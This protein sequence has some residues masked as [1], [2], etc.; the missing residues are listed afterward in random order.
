MLD[1]AIIPSK[2]PVYYVKEVSSTNDE[3]IKLSKDKNMSN[4]WVIAESQVKGR[5]RMGHSWESPKG[6]LFATLMFNAF[7]N[8]SN[9]SQLSLVASLSVSEA[10]KNFININENEVYLKWPN[11]ILVNRKK[12]SGV[13]IESKKDKNSLKIIIGIG[14]NTV[15]K[16][17]NIDSDPISL[18]ECSDKK[19]SNSKFF[20]TLLTYMDR[21]IVKLKNN[22]FKYI[23]N[24]WL[25]NA[26][27]FNKTI[28]VKQFG[29]ETITGIFCGLGNSGELVI[30]EDNKKTTIVNGTIL[31]F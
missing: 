26:I 1:S 19:I 23:R 9:I 4:F 15:K 11:D 12:I 31:E 14:V 6:N 16:P 17:N 18:Y 24:K 8:L 20:H 28:S 29:K 25:A 3:A 7:F 10:L 13:L 21:N 5:G 27:G 30:K 22:D 2:C